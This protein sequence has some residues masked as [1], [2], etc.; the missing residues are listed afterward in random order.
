MRSMLSLTALAVL[1][2]T[3]LVSLAPLWAQ[4]SRGTLL[5]R[6]TDPS[7][8]VLPNVAVEAVNN[9]TGVVVSAVT[10]NEGNYRIPYLLAG[11]YR[12]TFTIPGFQ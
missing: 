3:A 4:E 8:A 2:A 11:D 7:G 5:G 1:L 10:N 9:S 6:V 12:V